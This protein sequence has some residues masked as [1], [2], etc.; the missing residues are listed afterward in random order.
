MMGL[1]RAKLT[2]SP[3]CEDSVRQLSVKQEEFSPQPN[4]ASIL[5]LNCLQN[6][7]K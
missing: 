2:L 4:C 6:N 5:I 7:K 1:K 3:V